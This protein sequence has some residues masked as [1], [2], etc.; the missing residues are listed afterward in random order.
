MAEQNQAEQNQAEQGNGGYL[1]ESYDNQMNES[2]EYLY[3]PY[4]YDGDTF[5]DYEVEDQPVNACLERGVACVPIGYYGYMYNQ[6][7]F[8]QHVINI[9]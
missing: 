5:D 4:I 9:L 6:A 1:D 2:L 8:M 7:E 3:G